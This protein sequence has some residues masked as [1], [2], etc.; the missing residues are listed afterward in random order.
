VIV[1]SEIYSNKLEND[2]C[3]EKGTSP[4]TTNWNIGVRS[5]RR[6]SLQL[7]WARIIGSNLENDS[8]VSSDIHGINLYIILN[9]ISASKPAVSLYAI[10]TPSGISSA[11]AYD[12]KLITAGN[13]V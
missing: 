9:T 8:F 4:G 11:F 10:F 5:F 7:N 1:F 13:G 6:D 3:Y 2:T 12:T